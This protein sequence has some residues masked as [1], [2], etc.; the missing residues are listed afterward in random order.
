MVSVLQ[1]QPK[2][3]RPSIQLHACHF[4]LPGSAYSYAIKTLAAAAADSTTKQLF[5]DNNKQ[6]QQCRVQLQFVTLQEGDGENLST[7]RP[8]TNGRCLNSLRKLLAIQ[9]PSRAS[10]ETALKLTIHN[11][12]TID[13][14]STVRNFRL[15]IL[16]AAAAAAA[17][18]ADVG[19]IP[20]WKNN[21]NNRQRFARELRRSSSDICRDLVKFEGHHEPSASSIVVTSV[22]YNDHSGDCVAKLHLPYGYGTRLQFKIIPAGE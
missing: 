21:N 16:Y 12:A 2:G 17:A 22:N 10:A 5:L 14:L 20:A 7:S 4:V 13:Y 9:A 18:A 6:D 1:T 15:D 11:Y 19:G 8:A 3:W